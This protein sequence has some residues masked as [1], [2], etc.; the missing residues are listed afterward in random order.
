MY[1]NAFVELCLGYKGV[2]QESFIC[3]PPR[4]V[5]WAEGEIQGR[6]LTIVT[7]LSLVILLGSL[8]GLFQEIHHLGR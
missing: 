4:L 8:H 3:T 5:K 2:V 7:W 1:K 6:L